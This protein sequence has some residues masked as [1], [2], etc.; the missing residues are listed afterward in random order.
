LAITP[1]KATSA[2]VSADS[3]E[4]RAYNMII[5]INHTRAMFG[6]IYTRKSMVVLLENRVE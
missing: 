5:T 2:C 4:L 6:F 3:S 1:A